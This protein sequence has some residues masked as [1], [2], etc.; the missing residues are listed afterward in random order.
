MGVAA[1]EPTTRPMRADAARNRARILDAATNALA[2]EGPDA[3]LERI[4]SCAGVGIGTLYRHFPDRQSLLTAVYREGLEG[5]S[6][7]GRQLLETE[8]PFAALRD[9]MTSHLAFNR[10][11][12]AL[13]ASAIINMLD[14][15][16]EEAPPCEEMK[17][18]G[19][20]LL[21]RAK[22]AGAVRDDVVVEDLARLI[23]AIALAAD[24]A[25]EGSCICGDRLFNVMLDGLRPRA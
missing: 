5:I 25:P 12:Q 17:A 2:A 24:G 20:Q 13:A 4:A 19:Q 11:H 22:A 10:T 14:N 15:P 6:A 1:T 23:S 7:Y 16:D 18:V 3:P 8:D 21:D 9:W